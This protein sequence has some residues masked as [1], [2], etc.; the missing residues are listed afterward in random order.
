MISMIWQ[1]ISTALTL[2]IVLSI[3][4][5]IVLVVLF[6]KNLDRRLQNIETTLENLNKME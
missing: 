3:P 5:V 6:F 1:I 2:G 4:F